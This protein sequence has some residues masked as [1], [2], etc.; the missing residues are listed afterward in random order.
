VLGVLLI[1]FVRMVVGGGDDGTTAQPE[2]QATAQPTAPEGCTTVS[3][4]ASSEKAELLRS[5]ADTYNAQGAQVEGQC[6]WMAVSTKASG[7][8]ATALARGWDEAVDGTRPDVWTPAS[9]S[10]AVLVDQQ[11]TELDR[12]SP[13]PEDQPSLVQTPLVL[14]MPTPMA[15]ALGW[16]DAEIGWA[17]LAALAKAKDGWAS[18]GHPEWGRFKLGKTN[19]HYSTSGLNATIA[20]YFA[21][22]GVSSDL[23]EAQVADADTRAFVGRL[24]SAVVHYGDTTLTFLDNMARAAAE[25]QGL[26]YVSAVTVEEKSVL[27]Y[28]LGNPTGN[29]ATLGQQPAPSIPLAAVYPSDGTLVSDNPWL[30]LDAEWVTD[31]KRRA[32]G[33]FLAW[34]QEPAQQEQFQAA[35]FR[36]FEGA[37]GAIHTEANGMLPAGPAVVLDPPSPKVLAAVQY[38]W[39]ELRKRAHVLLVMDVSGSMGEIVEGAGQSKLELAQSAAI[40]ALDRFAANDEAGLWAFSTERGPSGEPWAKLQSIGPAGQTVPA[41]KA[42]I[43][44][45]VADGGTALYATLREAQA[46]MLGQLDT[47]RINAIILLS[48]GKN[49]YPPDTNLGSLLDQLQ[50][51]SVD[52]S[53]RVFTIGY[54][55]GADTEALTAIAE[56]SRGQYYEAND[57]TSIEK[58][59]TSV[60]SNF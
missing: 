24:E 36:T 12:P 32:A 37:P 45:M 51:E 39:D 55:E 15:Q 13:M 9:S 4:V 10:W 6:M 40:G 31:A 48:D 1:V 29:P 60:L 56:A 17:D 50:G 58:V 16:P 22:T 30:V 53:V 8:A 2:D 42:Q 28:N 54:G 26:T 23:T 44:T 11:A 43:A 20:S 46:D 3:V 47:K 49:E 19:P 25:G 33:D 38:S 18:Q 5:M 57:P 59:L 41:M 52:T 27:D 21:A 7:G 34:L 14:A 35:G